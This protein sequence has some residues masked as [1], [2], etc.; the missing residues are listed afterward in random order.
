ERA[1][2][3]YAEA[4]DAR[5]RLGLGVAGASGDDPEVDR[6][7]AELALAL[8]RANAAEALAS[9]LQADVAGNGGGSPAIGAYGD[10]ADPVS[11][12]AP[13]G[14]GGEDEAGRSLRY[15]L[16]RAADK[17]RPRDDGRS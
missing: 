5:A 12:P 10:A 11:E 15:R 16:A 17:K 6:L 4:E 3:A 14:D 9:R 13:A 8:E 7:R 2:H 1:R